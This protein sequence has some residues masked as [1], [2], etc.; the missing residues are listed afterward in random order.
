LVMSMQ[1]SIASCMILGV[2]DL[3][4]YQWIGLL[5]LLSCEMRFGFA[6][7]GPC[8][9]WRGV[10][11][12]LVLTGTLGSGLAGIGAI[13]NFRELQHLASYVSRHNAMAY[14]T[15]PHKLSCQT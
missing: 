2:R 9:T 10:T 15:C 12:S 14:D 7:G 8:V 13:G 4:L 6:I 3:V 5:S 11:I 1:A